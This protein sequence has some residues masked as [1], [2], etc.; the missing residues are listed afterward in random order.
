MAGGIFPGKPF[1]P[2]PKCVIISLVLTIGY[3][4]SP[5][6]N[7][8]VAM[9]MLFV[10]YIFIAWYDFAY[11]CDPM[12]YSNSIQSALK[13][14]DTVDMR[15]SELRAKQRGVFRFHLFIVAPLSIY[16]GTVGYRLAKENP[17]VYEGAFA[18]LGSAGGLA[19]LYHGYKGLI[20]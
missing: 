19:A 13:P 20:Q 3:W 6:K 18:L 4:I 2:N 7:A 17:N 8:V 1:H 5:K 15:T 16:C 14:D 9:V 10:T 12:I 11:N